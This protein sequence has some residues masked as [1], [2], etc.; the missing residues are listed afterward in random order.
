[1]ITRQNQLLRSSVFISLKSRNQN[2]DDMAPRSNASKVCLRARAERSK[3]RL[4][5]EVRLQMAIDFIHEKD[6]KASLRAVELLLCV[7]A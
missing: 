7:L 5:M 6:Q 4:E 2:T 1:M 3:K